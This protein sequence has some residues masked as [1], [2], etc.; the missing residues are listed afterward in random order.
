MSEQPE[1]PGALRLWHKELR[2]R[3]CGQDAARPSSWRFDALYRAAVC[4]AN[5]LDALRS[6]LAGQAAHWF[7][8]AER[9]IATAARARQEAA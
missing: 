2:L 1:P 3:Y 4:E 6:G 7:K 8:C 9:I 5:G